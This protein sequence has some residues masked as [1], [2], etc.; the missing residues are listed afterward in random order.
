MGLA[1]VAFAASLWISFNVF[2]LELITG[3]EGSYLFQAWNFVDGMVR[4]PVPPVYSL[5]SYDMILLKPEHGW[6]SRYSPGHPLWLV[7]GVMLGLPHL[8]TAFG[9]ALTVGGAYVCGRRLKIPRLMLPGLFLLSPYFLVLHGT[10]LS[11]TSGMAFTTMMLMFYIL[12]RQDHRTVYAFLAGIFWS[13]LFLNR[14]WTALLIAVPFGIDSL[15]QLGKDR[16]NLRLWT[17]TI[18]FA[19]TALLGIGLYMLYN[20]LSTGDAGTTTYL[21]YEPSENLGFG[22]RRVQGGAQYRVDHTV[23]RGLRQLWRNIRNLDRWMFGTPRYT[24]LVWLGLIAHGWN[25]RWSGLLLGAVA[26]VLLGYV[27][28][29]YPGVQTVGPVYQSETLPFLFLL[30]A[31]GFSRIWRRRWKNPRLR[32]V[33]FSMLAGFTAWRSSL[34]LQ[35]RAGRIEAEFGPRWALEQKISDLPDGSLLFYY[36]IFPD[37]RP[38]RHY[39]GLNVRG[40]DTPVLRLRAQPEYQPAIAAAFPDRTPFVLRDRPEIRIEPFEE[41]FADLMRRGSTWRSSPG[42]GRIEGDSRVTEP[43]ARPGFLYYGWYPFLP[44]GEYEAHFDMRWRDVP[45][46]RPVRIEIMRDFGRGTV[47]E[48]NIAGGL[49]TTV[50]I[51]QLDELT[52][53]EPRVHF[54]GAGS[55]ELR[56]IEIRRRGPPAIDRIERSETETE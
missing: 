46:D 26:A 2:Q 23:Q 4:R 30:G 45:E 24:L 41:P 27:A 16:R 48:K 20:Y 50:L 36:A 3:D 14:T 35:D 34:F 55:L 19:G 32:L 40:L 39:I 49:D 25:R 51:F 33:A 44:P 43:D 53:V 8:M 42:V 22:P 37:D 54:G 52:Q 56:R 9:A 5:L 13:L 15:L 17:G 38:M 1:L 47:A 6:L 29:W 7:P 18:L 12:W 31:L 21:F 28:F 10:L 11:H